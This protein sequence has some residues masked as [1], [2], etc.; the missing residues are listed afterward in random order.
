[1]GVTGKFEPVE[2]AGNVPPHVADSRAAV[3]NVVTVED[4]ALLKSIGIVVI[5]RNEGERLRGCL[6]SAVGLGCPVVYVDS[7]STDGSVAYAR[8]LGIEV[9]ELDRSRLFT[10]ALGRNTG[11]RRL[12]ELWPEM[13]FV[14]FIDGDC[15][16]CEGWLQAAGRFAV[17]HPEVGVVCGRR[18][19]IDAERNLYHRWTD[20]EWDTPV[21]EA[22]YCG[23]DALVR[24]AALQQVGGYREDLIA[25]EEPE[26]CVRLGQHGWKILRIDRDMTLHDIDIRSFGQW[27]RRSVRSGHAYAEGAVLHGSSPARHWVKESRSIWIW[28]AAIPILA[29][30]FAWP[31]GGLSIVA[32]MVAYFVLLVKIFLSRRSQRAEAYSRSASFAAMCLVMK[33]PQAIGQLLYWSRRLRRAPSEIIEY[34]SKRGIVAPKT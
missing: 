20:M 1:V 21:G 30:A 7:G 9:L 11:W 2:S 19:E 33:W 24:A 15:R 13:E 34:G 25:G 22:K 23:G 31:T 18:R 16:L 12:L 26:M 4:Q 29:V 5:G 6:S 3:K 14:Q 17:E 8:S 32:A 28:G 10:A 27:W